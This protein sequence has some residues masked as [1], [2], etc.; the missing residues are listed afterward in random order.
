VRKDKRL[1]D[2]TED[3]LHAAAQKHN[4][5]TEIMQKMTL[6]KSVDYFSSIN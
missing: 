4:T 3:A 2:P 1:S 5:Q 6:T